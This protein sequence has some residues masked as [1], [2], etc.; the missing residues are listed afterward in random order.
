MA[1]IT[2]VLIKVFRTPTATFWVLTA[3][4]S[5]SVALFAFSVRRG[6]PK[7]DADLLLVAI[8]CAVLVSYHTYPHDLC[9]LLVPVIVLL[10]TV[11]LKVPPARLLLN[12]AVLVFVSA[13]MVYF[14]PNQ[15]YWLT[16]PVFLLLLYAAKPRVLPGMAAE[17]SSGNVLQIDHALRRNKS[18]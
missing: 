2:A 6:Y 9:V 18:R 16:L 1:N 13:V 12:P 14:F 4:F 8:P 7:R 11:I 3:S 10:D 15:I 17:V 5:V